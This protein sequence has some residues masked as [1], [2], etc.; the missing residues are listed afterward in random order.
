MTACT[1]LLVLALIAFGAQSRTTGLPSLRSFS[2]LLIPVAVFVV[3]K[4][5]RTAVMFYVLA[6]GLVVASGLAINH[7]L[8][9]G[10][11]DGWLWAQAAAFGLSG[12][13]LLCRVRWAPYLWYA[14]VVALFI[15]V[16]E[17]A[18][19]GAQAQWQWTAAVLPLASALLWLTFGVGGAAA[20]AAH[21]RSSRNDSLAQGQEPTRRRRFDLLFGV[22][23]LA[24]SAWVA[25]NWFDSRIPDTAGIEQLHPSLRSRASGGANPPSCDKV[26]YCGKYVELSCHPEVDGLVSFHDNATGAL[27]MSCGGACMGG[28]GPAGT[29]R[30]SKCPPPEWQRCLSK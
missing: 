4:F 2:L 28:T 11:N 6:V 30:C 1:L 27:V 21:A 24:C 10:M 29:T 13:G 7:A 12:L 3:C 18:R 16:A 5:A 9:P 23:C 25:W 14:T 20:V 26:T 22:L 8:A 19:E 17:M 15:P